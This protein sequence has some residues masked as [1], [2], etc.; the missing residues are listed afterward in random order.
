MEKI[1]ILG[2]NISKVTKNQAASEAE[3]F[4]LSGGQHVIVTPNPEFL[5]A[6]R[7]DSEFKKILN[8]ADLAIPDGIGLLWAATVKNFRFQI[9]DFRFFRK[10][11]IWMQGVWMGLMLLIYPKSSQRVLPERVTGVDL[12]WEIARIAEQ[13]KCSMYLVGGQKDVAMATALKLKQRF[14]NLKIAGAE[15]GIM[16]YELRITNSKKYNQENEGLIL[17]INKARPDILLVAFGQ[18]KQEKWIYRNLKQLPSVKLAMGVGGAFDFIIGRAR[19]APKLLQKLGLEW[20][21]RL[22][23][24]PWR[25]NRI[26]TATFRFSRA[27]INDI[28]K[29]NSL[30]SGSKATFRSF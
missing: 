17:R 7:K 16:N 15:I 24:Q 25:F 26:L 21:W 12:I 4:L 2:V 5:M 9:S 19:R 20:F 8:E 11:K 22:I 23:F 18:V 13:K 6:A 29:D 28:I 27:V 1:N 14:T 10:V 3:K 30:E